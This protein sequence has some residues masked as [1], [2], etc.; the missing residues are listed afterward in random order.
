MKEWD[1]PYKNLITFIIIFERREK[2]SI[3]KEHV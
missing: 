3:I 1:S 2:F